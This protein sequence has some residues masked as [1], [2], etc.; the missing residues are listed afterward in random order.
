MNALNN[1][2]IEELL[3]RREIETE[4]PEVRRDLEGRS[5]LVTGAAG[6]VGSELVR[7]LARFSPG[8]AV[9]VDTAESPLYELGLELEESGAFGTLRI[10]LGDIRD[11]GRME[12]LF[13]RYRPD[14]VYHAAAYKHVPVIESMPIEGIKTNITGTRNVADAALRHG[15]EKFVLVSTDKAVNPTGVMGATKRIAEMY[16]RS[17]NGEGA[18]R[19]ITARFGN[20]LG[21]AGSVIPRFAHQ[22]ENGGPVTVTHPDVT[23]F[24]MTIPEAC[25]LLLQ[26]GALGAGGEIFVFDMGESV[27]ILDLAESMIRLSG[28]EPGR[29]IKIVFTGLR[30]G[31][32]LF[33]EVLYAAEEHLPTPHKL[34]FRAR[35]RDCP[36]DGIVPGLERLER[37]VSSGDPFAAIRVM[38]EMVPEYRSRNSAYE[39]IDIEMSEERTAK[40]AAPDKKQGTA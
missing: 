25:R 29:D 1:I 31:E 11:R 38:K 40:T 13:R 21:S 12:S 32:K 33:E 9:L 30:P 37:A 2:T 19:F 36:R 14:I 24:F 35:E 18:T 16:I 17:L 22:I 10:E 6:S 26:A 3:N 15:C 7:Q 8:A 20:V 4:C 39:Q 28:L 5:V 34:I 23:R 27:R